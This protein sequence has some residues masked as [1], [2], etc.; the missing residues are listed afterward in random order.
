[1][2]P[3]DNA[4]VSNGC[5]DLDKKDSAL[6]QGRI[7]TPT[8]EL[9]NNGFRPGSSLVTFKAELIDSESSS[10]DDVGESLLE[11][12]E[13]GV[14]GVRDYEIVMLEKMLVC[15]LCACKASN[16]PPLKMERG[17]IYGR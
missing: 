15:F 13:T 10:E 11:S 5:L 17:E 16:R 6:G 3:G 8:K 1:M 7:S 2:D 12:L 14:C 4:S 9:E